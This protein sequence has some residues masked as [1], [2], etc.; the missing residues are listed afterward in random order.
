M[1]QLYLDGKTAVPKENQ[2]IKLTAENPFFTNTASYTYDVELPLAIEEN[3]R[4]FGNINRMDISKKPRVMEARLIVDN[5]TVLTGTAHM[6]SVSESSVKVQLLGDSSS[7][8][9][10]N[11]MSET[12]ID[13]LDL[14]NWYMET[15]PDGSY[16]DERLQEW[17]HY[18]PD[19]EF[20]WGSAEVFLRA[21]YD[22]NGVSSNRTLM[23]RIYDGSLPWVAYP[24]VNSNA[25]FM[26]NGFAFRHKKGEGYEPF[27]R[28]YSGADF[29]DPEK[30]T[31]VYSMAIQPFVWKIAELIAR[32]TGFTL[33]REDNALYQDILFRRIFIVSANNMIE[34]NK[35]LPHWTVKEFWT[36][37]ENTFGLVLTTDYAN[38]KACLRKRSDHYREF[39]KRVSLKDVVDEYTADVDDETQSDISVS[40]VGFADFEA[41]PADLLDE[42]ITGNCKVNSE[43]IS[44]NQ[45]LLWGKGEP[46]SLKDC[47]GTLFKCRD[48]RQF[49]YTRA[50]GFVEVNQLRPRMTD[51]T[52]EDVDVELK[53]VPAHFIEGKCELYLMSEGEAKEKWEL[54]LIEVPYATFPAMMMEVP[55]ISRMDWYKRA[56]FFNL[57]IEGILNQT[58]EETSVAEDKDE[59]ISIAVVGQTY[60]DTWDA[61]ITYG[62]GTNGSFK[63]ATFPRPVIREKMK[64]ALTD[65]TPAREHA[66][67]SLSLIPIPGEEN[68]ANHTIGDAL[69]I[70]AKVRHC[71][72]FIAESIPDPT[73]IFLIHNRR[74]VCEK[75]EAD[76]DSYGLKKLL[77]GYFH[78]IDL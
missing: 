6:T 42:Y 74:F 50:E 46:E 7:Y 19:K 49:I 54:E 68:L 73:S 12:F 65:Y 52:K 13:E 1:I 69:V 27:I 18:H 24:V 67:Y 31:A 76:I 17:R 33:G 59:T 60:F 51:E 8:N 9:F 10:S 15:W 63:G 48:G 64:A 78:E 66:P 3:R 2:S 53:F 57:D 41:S 21:S 70:D 55:D 20:L 36:Q 5:I 45:L 61:I 30:N 28:G 56:G 71:I 23:D 25:D 58:E 43:F 44:A 29:A 39:A 72:R 14:G 38:R 4:I 32:G 37:V 40:N 22:E 75:I 77:T 26:C 62:N 47:K 16:W 11:R 34:C 35:C